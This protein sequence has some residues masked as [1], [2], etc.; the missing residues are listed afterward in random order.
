VSARRE[1]P[2]GLV[3]AYRPN[4]QDQHAYLGVARFGSGT[5]S[6]AMML[7]LGLFL[8]YVFQC[9]S[10]RKL[11]IETQEFNYEQFASGVDRYFEVE[12]R[13]R[14]HSFYG[15]RHWDQL[16]LAIYRETWMGIAERLPLLRWTPETRV[17]SVRVP[18]RPGVR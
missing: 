4:F 1:Q 12:G 18:P 7:G 2:I 3:T 17:K 11:Y 9:W 15:G 8:R 13:L 5:R 16:T 10:F 14:E 6:P